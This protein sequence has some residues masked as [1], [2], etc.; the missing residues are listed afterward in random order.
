VGF[1]TTRSA[2]SDRGAACFA[3]RGSCEPCLCTFISSSAKSTT[4]AGAVM[5]VSERSHRPSEFLSAWPSPWRVTWLKQLGGCSPSR[6]FIASRAALRQALAASPTSRQT[7]IQ[8]GHEP[9]KIL[10]RASL[11]WD[12]LR[13]DELKVDPDVVPGPNDKPGEHGD[14]GAL[15]KSSSLRSSTIGPTGMI[16]VSLSIAGIGAR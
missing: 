7:N 9:L 4:L 1:E 14:T 12:S 6:T 13:S 2:S 11:P 3:K 8:R 15:R 5:K 10:Q 16:N